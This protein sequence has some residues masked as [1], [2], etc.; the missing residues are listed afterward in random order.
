MD[1][2]TY[3]QL[4]VAEMRFRNFTVILLQYFC[5]SAIEEEVGITD[6]KELK[7][8]RIRKKT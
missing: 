8:H 4:F 7:Y 3:F 1:I 2:P 6:R 5:N